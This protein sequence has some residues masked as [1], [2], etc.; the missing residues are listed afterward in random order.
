MPAVVNLSAGTVDSNRGARRMMYPKSEN[1]DNKQN[2]EKALQLL[3]G[4]NSQ[5]IDVWW[6][7]KN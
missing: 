2:Y 4:A 3:G 7:K 6:A 1:S 5:G